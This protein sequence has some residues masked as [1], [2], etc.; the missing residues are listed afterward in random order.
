MYMKLI[1][2]KRQSVNAAVKQETLVLVKV[3]L[4]AI[5]WP[6]LSNCWKARQLIKT[7]ND[8]FVW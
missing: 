6:F 2:F 8:H 3:L 5:L 7:W 1:P 4:A